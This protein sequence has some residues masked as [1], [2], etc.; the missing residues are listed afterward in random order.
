[1]LSDTV[2]VSTHLM[3]ILFFQK[4]TDDDLIA[5]VSD[6]VFQPQVFWRLGD[7]QVDMSIL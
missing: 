2:G 1:M 6:E 7:V 4:V 3:Y 5:L